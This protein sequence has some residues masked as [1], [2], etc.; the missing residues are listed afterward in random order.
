MDSTQPPFDDVRVRMA[1]SHAID[2][3]GLVSAI[4]RGFGTPLA[5]IFIPQTFGFDPSVQ[6][7]YNVEKAKEL[8]AEAG[9]PDGFEVEFDTFTGSITDH[10]RVAEAIVG[11][12]EEVGIEASLNVA[13][14]ATWGPQRLANATSPIY[15]YS[16]G[17]AYFDHGPNLK[18]F[19]SGAQG[20]YY[21]GDEELEALIDEALASFDD[22]ERSAL[23]S[24]IIRQF[25]EKGILVGLYRM[26]QIWAADK[27]VDY[28]P[29]SDEMYRFFLAKPK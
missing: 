18:T 9:Y 26:D 7:E 10:S 6:P 1:V 19:I 8:L 22:E 16:F 25:Y 14:I 4:Q 27:D 17:D 5:G 13:D 24:E 28:T 29:Q 3:E 12:L 21:S 20:Y 23:Y 2:R 15:N 11:M